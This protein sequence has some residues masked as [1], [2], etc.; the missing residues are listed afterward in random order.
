[1]R[2]DGKGPTLS[3]YPMMFFYDVT[4]FNKDYYECGLVNLDSMDDELN[5]LIDY[6]CQP[7]HTVTRR[8]TRYGE[9]IEIGWFA[10]KSSIEKYY[11]FIWKE[12]KDCLHFESKNVKYVTLKIQSRNGLKEFTKA[13]IKAVVAK[14]VDRKDLKAK[15]LVLLRLVRRYQCVTNVTNYSQCKPWIDDKANCKM[16]ANDSKDIEIINKKQFYKN[17]SIESCNF[18][19]E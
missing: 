2:T 6:Y 9:R 5:E 15:L 18:M 17:D 14:A 16:F 1:M 3:R 7:A 12:A 4:I 13:N 11:P 8:D 19:D 10:G